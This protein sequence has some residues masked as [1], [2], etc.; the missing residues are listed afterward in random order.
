[1]IALL[2]GFLQ[3]RKWTEI[4]RNQTQSRIKSGSALRNGALIQSLGRGSAGEQTDDEGAGGAAE[5][6]DSLGIT[7]ELRDVGLHPLERRKGVENAIVPRA[8]A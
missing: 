3:R 5:N 7:A 6:G 8:L 4:S 1:M 2:C